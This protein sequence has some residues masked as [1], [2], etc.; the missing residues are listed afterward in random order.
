M[1]ILKKIL[2]W[3]YKKKYDAVNNTCTQR[4]L[5]WKSTRSISLKDWKKNPLKTYPPDIKNCGRHTYAGVCFSCLLPEESSIGSFC[6][7][8]ANVQIGHGEHPLNFLST[9]SYFYLDCLGWKSSSVPSHNEFWKPKPV[10]IG[11]DV[12]IGDNVI[13]KNG[14]TVGNGAVIGANSVITKD[15]PPYS[16]VAGV[17]AKIIRFRFTEDIICRLQKI[18]W[19]DLD[20]S[21]LRTLTYDDIEKTL[22]VLENI[23]IKSKREDE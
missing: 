11:N 12:W 8:G 22:S 21:V 2:N 19:W 23:T 6:S 16:I 18:K 4:F 14:I 9:S 7:I 17:P 20:D 13:I 15:V 10:I 1:K 5:F 3:F